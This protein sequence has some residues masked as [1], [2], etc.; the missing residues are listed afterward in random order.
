MLKVENYIIGQGW[1]TIFVL[2]PHQAF[3]NLAGHIQV[4]YANLKLIGFMWL[5]VVNFIN[6]VLAR[7][8]YEFFA[9][10]KM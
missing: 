6:I 8:W 5:A 9:K 2:R 3:L 1:A 10:A 7:F 4:K